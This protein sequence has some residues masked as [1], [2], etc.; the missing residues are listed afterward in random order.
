VSGIKK[1][2]WACLCAL[3]VLATAGSPQPAGPLADSWPT[4]SGDYSGRRYSELSQVTRDNVK[5]L[6]LAWATRLTGG[7]DTGGGGMFAPPSP[8]QIVG[9]EATD[10]VVTGGLFSSAAPISIRGAILEVNGV[11]YAS[12]PDNVWAI[13]AR[14]GAVLWHY[15]WKTKGGTHTSN[16]GMG[17]YGDWLFVETA[18]D[19]L[20]S[21]DARTGK[22]R[23]HKE[24]AS[25]AEQYFSEAA[26]IVIGNH[27]LVGA[28]NDGDEPGSLRSVDPATGEPQWK[29]H[30]TPMNAGDPGLDSWPSLEA[31]RHGGGNPW[32]A[33]SYDPET[34]L[35]IFGSGNPS[36]AYSSK[37]RAGDNLFTNSLI[38]VNVDSGKMAWYYQT[39]P[40]DTHDWDSAETPILVDGQ[41]NGK[42]RKLVLQATRNGHFFVLDRVTGKHLLT[43]RFTPWGKWVQ[44]INERGQP[45]RDPGRDVTVGGTVLSVDG[46]TNWPPPAFSPQ[47]GFFY[48]RGFENYGLLYYTETDPAGTM[49]LGGV[50]RGGQVSL[51]S[52]IRAIDYRTGK[53]A[54]EHD[55]GTGQGF[56]STLGSGLLAT[57]GGI[58]F[59]ADQGNNFVAFDSERGTPLWHSRLQNVSNAPE[60]FMLD[61]HQ[62]VMVAADDMIYAFALY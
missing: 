17:I 60:A 61:G 50:T 52:S 3:P 12:A 31:A 44:Q 56:M 29:F 24:I 9:G 51:G 57:A 14:T 39:A 49:G 10:A 25:F 43:T 45:V 2:L 36:P 27:V 26:P 19:Y 48:V 30:I 41:F 28:A 16:K 32:T 47:T 35:Y 1:S 15:Y 58:L 53:V 33:G 6:T 18:D 4:Y 46:W 11:L 20:V 55:F 13:D 8:P 59:G 22:E 23:W 37:T 21:L 40:H 34:H 42:P 7:M 5:N 62:Y 38:A 54:W